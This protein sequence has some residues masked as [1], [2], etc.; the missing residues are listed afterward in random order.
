M[1]LKGCSG[2]AERGQC[3][4]CGGKLLGSSDEF[5]AQLRVVRTIAKCENQVGDNNEDWMG[6]K[7]IWATNC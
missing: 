3:R 2:F 4:E 7:K 1:H 5:T 6:S